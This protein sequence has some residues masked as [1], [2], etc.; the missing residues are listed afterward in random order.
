MADGA[1]AGRRRTRPAVRRRGRDAGAWRAAAAQDSMVGGSAGF[2]GV[3]VSD[4]GRSGR[5]L[6]PARAGVPRAVRP[7]RRGRQ[8]GAVDRRRPSRE[9]HPRRGRPAHCRRAVVVPGAKEPGGCAAR[10][11]PR[12]HGARGGD[13]LRRPR[14]LC[15]HARVPARRPAP[16]PYPRG[17][18]RAGGRRRRTL[19]GRALLTGTGRS[20]CPELG[21]GRGVGQPWLRRRGTRPPLRLGRRRPGRRPDRPYEGHCHGGCR[22]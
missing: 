7:L 11:L 15:R 5:R 9:G 10:C 22:A 20:A 21:M 17:G 13:G 12:A 16:R 3:S 8:R 2:A 19:P 6:G 18:R 14:R 4:R 1:R